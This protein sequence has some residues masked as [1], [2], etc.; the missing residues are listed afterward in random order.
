[1]STV[2]ILILGSGAVAGPCVDYLLRNPRNKLVIGCRNLETGT[3]VAAGRDNI[4]AV[5]IDVED[6]TE[7]D[8]RVAASDLVISL[9]PYA[10][11]AN[12]ILAAIKGKTNVVTTSYTSPAMRELETDIKNAGI[13]VLNEVGVDPG[14]DH[15]YA[16]KMISEVHSKGGKI[17][18]F[19]S[20]CGGLAMPEV[21]NNP[22]RFKFSWSPRGALLSQYNPAIFLQNNKVVE[23]SR[24]DLMD[25]AQPR[26]VGEGYSFVAYPNR[27]ST[28]F[29]DFYGIPEAHTVV[30]G[31][32]RYEGNPELFRALVKL[33]WLDTEPSEC[34]QQ[35][36]T[37][38]Q[39]Q[40]RLI[41]AAGSDER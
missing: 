20:Y 23:I 24:D 27:D 38:A 13:T 37:W 10:H 35:G 17:R 30:R 2:Q 1:M 11:H 31:S 25:H 8:R 18:E 29:R 36:S 32:L 15:L 40:S 39:I 19:H 34:L 28:P 14:V 26:F 41:R 4:Q 12:V 3:A 9:V 16:I 7:L 22:L 21:S 6:L 5:Q 33:G